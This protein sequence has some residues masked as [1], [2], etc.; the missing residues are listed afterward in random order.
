MT[1]RTNS[2]GYLLA[3]ILVLLAFPTFADEYEGTCRTEDRIFISHAGVGDGESENWQQASDA[4]IDRVCAVF[5]ILRD[6]GIT[7]AVRMCDRAIPFVAACGVLDNE[8]VQVC[9]EVV[10]GTIRYLDQLCSP[11]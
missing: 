6:A 11:S 2:T 7:T 3:I 10:S 9:G 1:T 4:V 8:L 5:N